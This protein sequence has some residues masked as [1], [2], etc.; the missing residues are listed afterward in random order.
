MKEYIVF[1]DNKNTILLA[2]NGRRSAGKHGCALNIQ[3]FY[4]TDLTCKE[5]VKVVY[6][7]TNEMIGDF[8]TK[9][10]QGMKFIK[11]HNMILG[12]E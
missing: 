9:P 6:C 1:Q 7:P 11:F 3:Y 10:L 12:I 2:K 5:S 4:A 8:M